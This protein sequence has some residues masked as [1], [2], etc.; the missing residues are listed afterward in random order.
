[1]ARLET[2]DEVASAVVRKTIPP[3]TKQYGE[4]DGDLIDVFCPAGRG[5]AP[6][7]VFI[8]GGAWTR[9]TRDD[10]SYPAPTFM[11]RGVAYLAPDFGSLKAVRLAQM[12]ESCRAAVAWTIRNAKS[13]GGDPSR[14]FLA[15]HSSGA[16]L[17][18]CVLTT[19]WTVRGLPP[20]AL[21]GGFLMSGMY[22][23]YPV[24]LSSRSTYLHLTPG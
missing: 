6:V 23:L 2:A 3:V 16:H 20:G 4:A 15:G 11:G 9:N 17:A 8:H 19:D 12:V 18:A 13:F 10:V 5:P 22:D 14:V 21:K 7:L 1:M 24:L